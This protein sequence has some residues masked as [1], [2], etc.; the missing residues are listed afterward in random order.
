MPISSKSG[1]SHPIATPAP[2]P[3]PVIKP[4]VTAALPDWWGVILSHQTATGKEYIP[5]VTPLTRAIAA[6]DL[7]PIAYGQVRIGGSAL[8]YGVINPGSSTWKE[9]QCL[10][11]WS[12][13]AISSIDKVYCNGNQ[14]RAGFANDGYQTFDRLDFT[15][16]PG[17]LNSYIG[18]YFNSSLG[19][20]AVANRVAGTYFHVLITANF[21]YSNTGWWTVFGGL[22]TGATLEFSADVHGVLLYDPRLDST[23]GGT[24]P[25]RENDESTWTY[26]TCPPLIV[27]DLLRRYGRLT[28]ATID[29]ASIIT[30]AN[31]S[32]AA[33]FSCNI[34]FAEK[35]TLDQ[36]LAAVLQTCNGKLITSNGKAGLFL[37]VPNASPAVA[38]FSEADGD[39]WDLNYEW[40]SARD[41]Y[42]QCA[43]AFSNR[44]ADYKQDQTPL[45][46]DPGTFSSEPTVAFSS[47]NTGTD[48]ITLASSPGWAVGDEVLFFQNGGTAIGGLN[49]GQIY[50]VKTI[51]GADV[52][53]TEVLGGATLDLTGSPVVTTQYLQ[54]IGIDYPPTVAVK[55]LILSSPGVN[56]LAAA[57]ILRDYI[58]NSQAI[59]FR[60]SGMMNTRGILLQEGMKITLA[61]L[62]G[63]TGDF[64]IIQIAGDGSG[65]FQ[66]VVKPYSASVYGS[67]PITVQPPIVITPPNPQDA[68][69]DITV[70]DDTGTVQVAASSSSNTQVFNLY[71]KIVYQLP[72][73]QALAFL[74]VRG[75]K[76][77]GAHTK[78]W[79]DMADSERQIPIG[80]N[81][82][83]PDATHNALTFDPVIKTVRTLTFDQS[84][85]LDT[86][87]DVTLDERIII[88]TATS[89][90]TT[91]A[92]V[93]VDVSAST[94]TVTNPRTDVPRFNWEKP[95]SGTVDGSNKVF[96]I[97]H[98]WVTGTLMV[99]ADGQVMVDASFSPVQG[100]DYS[101]S[102]NNVT[103]V[104]APNSWVGF[105]YQR[106]VN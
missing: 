40:L 53:L 33:G 7:L 75:F 17:E 65:F 56:T 68:P 59:T 27:R 25:Q 38:S 48:T 5:P 67:T 50:Y 26:S 6:T 94:N 70:T 72:T 71:Q 84:G 87:V 8:I 63:V 36:A 46:G 11:A 49:D 1:R 9:G 54:R 98:N 89:A 77:T 60:I 32:D 31:A 35:I 24:G 57:I 52:T 64:L 106:S 101:V 20:L 91:S 76:G 15:G 100:G 10:I 13:G 4:P 21:V 16:V 34:A 42:T 88:K 69:D 14:V 66:F 95:S 51:S 30:S 81:Q 55:G 12:E 97:P 2:K 82:P 73:A 22:E 105:L 102:G 37:D 44:D 45:F 83:P 103:F 74:V 3:T 62:K 41:R 58:F 92:G 90:G 29:D 39:I 80:G 19:A 96:V 85:Q 99:I 86:T 43:V 23:N 47:V 78:T 104:N 93:T 79:G 18:G 61:T 28:S